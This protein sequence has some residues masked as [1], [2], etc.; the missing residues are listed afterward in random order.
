VASA[1]LAGAAARDGGTR[2]HKPL[3]RH[4]V[5]RYGMRPLLVGSDVV[6]VLLAGTVVGGFTGGD[7]VLAALVVMS[8]ASGD[9]YRSRL[10]MSSLDDLPALAGRAMVAGAVATSMA[11]MVGAR[12]TNGL[13]LAAAIAAALVPLG[14]T[15]CCAIVRRVR[16]SRIIEHPTLILGA[17]VVGARLATVL[18]EHPEYGLAPVGFLDSDPLLPAERLPVPLL[19]G[20]DELA[21]VIERLG[22][23]DVIVAFASVRESE[24]V[25]V[26]RTCDRLNCEILFV[27]RLFEL[28]STTRDTDN[29]WGVPVLR[30]RRAPFRSPLWQVKRILDVVVAGLA[31]LLLSPVLLACALAVKIESREGVVFSQERVGI[32]GRPFKLLKF[33]SMHPADDA[34]S[35]TQW[36]IA[37]DGRVGSVGRLLRRSSLDE[38]PQLWNILRG[39]MTLVGPRPER[40]HFVTQFA[41]TYPWYTARHRVPAGLTGWAQIHGLRGDTSIEDRARFDNFY[42]ENW[43]LWTDCKIMLRTVGQVIR[44]AGR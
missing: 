41:K 23:E 43:S 32:D 38:L 36:N 26:I 39:D 28:A 9:L 14:R 22:V 37:H 19:A 34:E 25:S 10:S 12:T 2:E 35:Q 18:I 21:K 3:G 44:C 16:A 24:M 6:A 31:L 20:H 29:I 11:A 17:G 1:R 27:P 4:V 42:I 7:A 5:L 15:V 13:L 40:P 33:R 8:Y 30:L